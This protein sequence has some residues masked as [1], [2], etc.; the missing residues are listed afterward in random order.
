VEQIYQRALA[1]YGPRPDGELLAV[2]ME[3][4][5]GVLLRR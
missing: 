1:R 5:A 4:G 3:E 2:A